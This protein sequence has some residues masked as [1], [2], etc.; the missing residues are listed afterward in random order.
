MAEFSVAS[1]AG[2][3]RFELF[4]MGVDLRTFGRR[5]GI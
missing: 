3:V 2:G 1:F 5:L 4:E